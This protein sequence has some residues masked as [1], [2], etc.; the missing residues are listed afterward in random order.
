M[1]NLKSRVAVVLLGVAVLW[2]AGCGHHESKL[3]ALADVPDTRTPIRLPV[4]ADRAH[5]EVMMMHLET[6]QVLT[7]ALA[8]GDYELARG[9]MEA[10]LGFFARRHVAIRQKMETIPPEYR[11]FA[12]AHVDAV[13]ELTAIIPSKDLKQILPRVNAMLKT[14]MACHLEFRSDGTSPH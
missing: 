14:C 10:H 4:E 2:T 3:E 11:A 8:D 12:A 9:V 13:K 6:V 7:G 1:A 5:R